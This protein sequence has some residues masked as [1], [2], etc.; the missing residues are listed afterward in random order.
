M[1][2]NESAT[3]AGL[4]AAALKRATA[5]REARKAKAQQLRD[6]GFGGAVDR[7]T[8]RLM[9]GEIDADRYW[10]IIEGAAEL[11]SWPAGGI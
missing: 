6:L 10:E 5:R 7:L 3:R 2:D 8:D 1:E 11:L 9:D 4:Q